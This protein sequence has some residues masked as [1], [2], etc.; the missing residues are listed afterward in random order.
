MELSYICDTDVLVVGG[1]AAGIRAAIAA[2]RKRASVLLCSKVKIGCG[3]STFYPGME[4]IGYSAITHPEAGDSEEQFYHEI[5]QAASGAADPALARVLAWESTPRFR[6]LEESG[7]AFRRAE[8]G[9]YLSVVPCFGQLPRGANAPV[10]SYRDALWRQLMASGAS[11]RAGVTMLALVTQGEVCCGAVGLDELGKL[12]YFRAKA[13]ILATGGASSLYQYSLSTPV[14]TGD[15]YVM[16]YDCGA[17]LV[18][19]EFIQFGL[20]LTWPIPKMDFWS[21]S[22][23]TCP[24]ITNRFGEEFLPRYLPR[25]LSVGDCLTARVHDDPFSTTNGGHYLDIALFEEARKGNAMP[26]GGLH[27]RFDK[28]SL[29]QDRQP[30][31][32]LWLQQM[33]QAHIDLF[34]EG[35]DV[36]PHAFA[37]NGGIYINPDAGTGIPGLFAA[38]ETAGG[39]H[40]ANRLGGNAMA[41]TQVFGQLAGEN[42]AGFALASPRSHLTS[43]ELTLQLQEKF[44]RGGG[45]V[46]VS[47]M[48][49]EVRAIMWRCGSLV[50]EE[51]RCEEGLEQLERL[52]RSFSLWRHLRD[53]VDVRGAASLYSCLTLSRLLLELIRYRR[54]SRGP[55]CRL[56]YP[57]PNREYQG[58][59]SAQK[60]DG[61]LTLKLH[62]M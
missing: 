8:D 21:K 58:F 2:R 55:H 34:E 59:L 46:G 4:S 13:T 16:A 50:R 12:A 15:G 3:G 33:E 22:L 48:L 20:G 45:I 30:Y 6:Q 56:D 19:L 37:F 41:A 10:A 9:G 31:T 11:V 27:L 52:S 53:N 17:R 29:L 7:V 23:L 38:G 25:H 14:Q 39:P 32:K 49:A 35:I 61:Q 36:L 54:E 1:G 28:A 57:R 5:L 44:D 26:S 24:T 40:G 62:R 51:S 60:Q 42:A 43:E 18:N 47:A